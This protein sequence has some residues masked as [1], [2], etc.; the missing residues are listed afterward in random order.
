M[1]YLAVKVCGANNCLTEFSSNLAG[2]PGLWD[3]EDN[4]CTRST[5]SVS[6]MARMAIVFVKKKVLGGWMCV[7]FV[8]VLHY[9][10]R[11]Y[12]VKIKMFACFYRRF[13][14]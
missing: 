13:G 5:N 1:S 9:I 10:P 8:K 14:G 11:E 4:C 12:V 3:E 2:A 7:N 6:Q